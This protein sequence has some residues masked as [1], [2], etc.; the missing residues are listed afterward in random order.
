MDLVQEKKKKTKADETIFRNKYENIS[1]V[2]II[3]AIL[4]NWDLTIHHTMHSVY[5]FVVVFLFKCVHYECQS[6]FL[7]SQ[8]SSVLYVFYSFLNL[9]LCQ[10]VVVFIEVSFN[11]TQLRV[12][13]SQ[14]VGNVTRGQWELKS[15]T[16]D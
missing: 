3:Y 11:C 8:F 7:S 14:N 2:C 4:R 13:H 10:C 16:L 6:V 12:V 9:L 5:V 1:F 15:H